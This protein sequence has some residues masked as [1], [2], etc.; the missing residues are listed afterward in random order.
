[1]EELARDGGYDVL[2]PRREEVDLSDAAATSRFFKRAAPDVVFHLA[3]RV[4]GIGGNL[5]AP[6]EMFYENVVINTH[7]IEAARLGG[8][9]KFVAVGSAAIYSDA[10]SLPMREDD[11]WQGPPH[12][13]EGPY[14]H[15]KRSML[16]HLEAYHAQY[17]MEFVY[18]ILTNTF[19]PRDRFDEQRGHVLPSLISKFHRGVAANEPVV[20]WGTGTAR[21][22]FLYVKDVA[23][24]LRSLSAA[25]I[26][27]VNVAS[28]REVSIRDL[29]FLIRD[30][31]GYKGPVHWDTDKPNGQELRQ[32]DIGR[33]RSVGFTPDYTLER[34]V[35][36]TYEWYVHNHASV[37]R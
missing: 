20:V 35:A 12:H 9:K 17:G 4:A 2:A 27:P 13:S 8:A 23:K 5:A 33:L 37:R 10:V 24:A 31:S 14:G 11:L 25:G 30:V 29:A 21:R 28:G 19:G 15:A 7:V 26:G 16:A 18:C 32:Y 22:D 34:A 3:A 6:G 1:M 36:E